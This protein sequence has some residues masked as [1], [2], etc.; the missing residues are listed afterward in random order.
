MALEVL[1]SYT[2]PTDGVPPAALSV[3]VNALASRLGVS[4]R[5]WEANGLGPARTS[6]ACA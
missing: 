4:V 3:R 6:A 2:W 1:V 5:A